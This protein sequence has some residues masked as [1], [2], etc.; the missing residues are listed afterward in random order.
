MSRSQPQKWQWYLACTLLLVWLLPIVP[1]HNGSEPTSTSPHHHHA[2]KNASSLPEI[3]QKL[4]QRFSI[5]RHVAMSRPEGT[6]HHHKRMAG[7]ECSTTSFILITEYQFGNSGNNLIS[8]TNMLWLASVLNATLAVP[9]YMD[10]IL[11]PFD[12]TTLHKTHCFVVPDSKP[13][14][15]INDIV[16]KKAGHRVYEVESEDAFFLY[17]LFNH[18]QYAPLLPAYNPALIA[19]LSHHYLR[20]YSGFWC[21]PKP[22]IVAAAEYIIMNHLGGAGLTYSSVHKRS[23]E[24][25]CSKVPPLPLRD[26]SSMNTHNAHSGSIDRCEQNILS[27]CVLHQF[28]IFVS[29]VSCLVMLRNPVTSLLASC[30]WTVWSGPA[31]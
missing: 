16:D 26:L 4:K 24:G 19:E 22:D 9:P 2:V 28:Y 14:T 8:F 18:T 3:R 23:M 11:K 7:K 27:L 15:R 25:G 21:C 17:K 6:Q 31:I 12:L 13:G 1:Q 10:T 20:V 5:L 30:R 29:C